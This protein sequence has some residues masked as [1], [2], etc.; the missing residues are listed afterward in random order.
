MAKY[1]IAN[2]VW[3]HL[4]SLFK[5]INFAKEYQLENDIRALHQENMSIHE[6]Y[7]V[8]MDFWDQL[9]LTKSAKLKACDAY[10]AHRE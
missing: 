6:F 10:I 2:K 9:T 7:F 8:M 5:K 3:V 4:Q 1:K